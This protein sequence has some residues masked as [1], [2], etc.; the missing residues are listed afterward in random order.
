MLSPM[1]PKGAKPIKTSVFLP[2]KIHRS[3]KEE[4]EAHEMSTSAWIAQLVARKLGMSAEDSR[5]YGETY[6]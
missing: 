2:P 3:A 1:K 5:K 4:A 6:Y